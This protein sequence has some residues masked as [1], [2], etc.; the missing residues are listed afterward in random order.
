MKIKTQTQTQNHKNKSTQ[1]TTITA[2]GNMCGLQKIKEGVEDWFETSEKRYWCE[3]AWEN[4]T[5]G[6]CTTGVEKTERIV[7][8]SHRSLAGAQ[9]P[10]DE[11]PRV[12]MIYAREGTKEGHHQSGE[13]TK[14][15]ADE[16]PQV[17]KIYARDDLKKQ[18]SEEQTWPDSEQQFEQTIFTISS[19]NIKGDLQAFVNQKE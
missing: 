10:A 9:I 12:G 17:G 7:G 15:A 14:T 3:E 16:V 6:K 4:G 2:N 11:V 13:G 18:E 8:K 5:F 19:E 1:L